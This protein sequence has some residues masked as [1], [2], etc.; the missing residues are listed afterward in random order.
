MNPTY[1]LSSTSV[2]C[3]LIIS[4]SLGFEITESEIYS[5]GSLIP[6]K[7]L[8]FIPGDTVELKCVTSDWYEFCSWKH[9]NQICRFEWKRSYGDVKKQSCDTN[10]NDRIKF[11]GKYNKYDCSIELSNLTL[12][13]AGEWTCDLESYVWGPISGTTDTA[14]FNLMIDSDLDYNETSI[15]TSIEHENENEGKLRLN[16]R[17]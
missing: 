12:S 13:D 8:S 1:I 14:Q 11:V 7:Q 10:W 4:Y 2:L 15:D 16:S 17:Y 9:E 6:E 5:N 3:V